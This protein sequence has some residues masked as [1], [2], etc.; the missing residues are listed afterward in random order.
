MTPY[1]V[2]VVGT[3]GIGSATVHQLAK[4]GVRVLGLDRFPAGHDRGSS[5]GATRVI[6][7]AYFEHPDYVPLL[8]QAYR[9]WAELETD[10]GV[11]LYDPV[12]LLEVGPPHGLII[13]RLRQCAREHQLAID[14]LD[15]QS[16]PLEFPAFHFPEDFVGVFER[17]AGYLWVERA[18][19]CHLDEARRLGA[20][21]SL[22]ETVENWS[23]LATGE[24]EVRTNKSTYRSAKLILTAGP[25]AGTFLGTA[26]CRLR[27]LRKHLHW[28]PSRS[29]HPPARCTFLAEMPDGIY[30]GFP[31]LDQRG[32][33]VGEHSGGEVV[34][35]PLR[36]SREPDEQDT[37][38][39]RR[40]V[41]ACLPEAVWPPVDHAV[42]F[43][44]MSA[45]D[46]FIV[47]LHP[48]HR[49]VA[50]CAGLSGHGF[51]FAPILGKI[52]ADLALESQTPEPIG[53]LSRSR[54]DRHA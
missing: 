46:Q 7:Q 11:S 49:Q 53:F 23:V 3:G 36:A 31:A 38:R 48:Q 25:W 22:A 27:V 13:P 50:F 5:H 18:V 19:T 29:D 9:L 28:L 37:Q 12:G 20:A 4:R 6:R 15:S 51:K 30:Y 16:L 34:T 40:F 45:D 1:D 24:C 42:C 43:Y 54:F 35:D 44:T 17:E 41:T 21:L 8:K 33:K 32:L 39:V 10:T 2:I 47:D 52:L 26:T 14:E